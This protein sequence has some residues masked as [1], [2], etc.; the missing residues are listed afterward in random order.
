MKKYTI[1]DI[2]E[3]SGVSVAT[4]SRVINNNGRFS[5]ET[6]EK[7]KKVIAETG[8]QPNYSAKSL[9]MN[10]SL[11]IGI[12]V[13]DITN[14]FFA[15]VVQKIEE[16]FFLEGYTTIICHTSRNKDKE[17]I[18]LDILESKGVDGL[19]VISGAEEFDFEHFDNSEKIIPYICIDRAPK[20]KKNTIFISSDH[21]QG[22]RYATEALIK[23]GSAS[24]IFISHHRKSTS[25]TER[26]KGFRD[27][28]K[29]NNIKFSSQS[30]YISLDF[31]SENCEHELIDFFNKYPSTDGVF[32]VNDIVAVKVLKV[33]KRLN[34]N[35]PG[36]LKIIGFDNTNL[37]ENVSPKL[38]SVKQDTD[39][40][41]LYTVKNLLNLI[42]NPKNTGGTIKVPVSLKLRE[43]TQDNLFHS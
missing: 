27:S 38:S 2:A 36:D 33:L 34:I 43:S 37:S 22:A 7:V 30:H 18:Y 31:D 16:L 41:A 39:K 11:S 23:S 13:P 6:R 32:A 19:V 9:R 42:V 10:K 12:L 15:E 26:F 4:V 40:I 21:Y 24:P 25:R 20:N 14:S 1:K 29:E 3:L 28:L 35:V 8:Y 17:K 5:E